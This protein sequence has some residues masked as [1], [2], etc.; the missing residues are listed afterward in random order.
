VREEAF[1]ST[2]GRAIEAALDKQATKLAVLD[3]T[4]LGA[5]AE[6]FVL[7]TA[8]STPQMRAIADAVEENLNHEGRRPEHREGGTESEWLLL[9]YGEFVVHIFSERGREY[10]DLERLW[11]AAPKWSA[12][13]AQE[14]VPEAE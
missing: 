9:D 3:L 2:I 12:P 1:P 11:R 8:G 7:C 10:Y 5:F 13:E 4:G 6:Y 14:V